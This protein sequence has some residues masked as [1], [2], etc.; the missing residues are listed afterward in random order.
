MKKKIVCFLLIIVIL[1]MNSVCLYAD[2][3]DAGETKKYIYTIDYLAITGTFN[4]YGNKY[5]GVI[6]G[7]GTIES[8]YIIVGFRS[9][10]NVE[11]RLF[12]SDGS[13][14]NTVSNNASNFSL[15]CSVSGFTEGGYAYWDTL[16]FDKE[17]YSSKYWSGNGLSGSLHW[18]GYDYLQDDNPGYLNTNIPIFATEDEAYKY[19]AGELTEKDAVNYE[20]DL[21]NIKYD[22]EVPQNLKVE[23]DLVGIFRDPEYRF[24]WEQTVEDYTKW[25]TEIYVYGDFYGYDGVLGIPIGDDYVYEKE[26]IFKD[27]FDTYKLR[28]VIATES[29]KYDNGY[30]AVLQRLFE[31]EPGN[32]T[33]SVEAYHVYIRNSYFDGNEQHYSN[34]VYVSFDHDFSGVNDLVVIEVEGSVED[35]PGNIGSGTGINGNVN[36]DSQY[37]G[38]IDV[39]WQESND[40]IV[41]WISN[42]FG[43]LG[44]NGVISLLQD[45]FSFIPSFIWA[46]IATGV[47]LMV[48]IGVIKYVF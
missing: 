10:Q 38:S 47:G 2:E 13:F 21:C 18:E 15:Y 32:T 27:V 19:A 36:N 25:D 7:K 43:L 41:S 31:L 8:D 23:F 37:D 33:F 22:L 44:D 9:G 4:S 26:F 39:N 35:S 1:L 11:I 20:S 34:W 29:Y 16:E 17:N 48:L 6:K 28:Y 24:K 30:D 45:A 46:I 5:I 42:G 12:N 3:S 14:F 40:D